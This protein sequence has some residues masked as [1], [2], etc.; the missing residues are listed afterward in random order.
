MERQRLAGNVAGHILGQRADVDV[1]LGI[2]QQVGRDHRPGVRILD[3]GQPL[4]VSFETFQFSAPSGC[5]LNDGFIRIF[6]SIDDLEYSIDGEI[7]QGGNIN[8]F[9]DILTDAAL[10]GKCINF[11]WNRDKNE[12]TMVNVYPQC[13]CEC[14]K[15][16]D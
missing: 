12:M 1:I 4:P 3:L 5:S 15:T 2:G 11:C 8:D 14:E 13:C 10:H 16:I 7:Y 9:R 6:T